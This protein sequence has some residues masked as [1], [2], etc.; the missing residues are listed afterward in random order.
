MHQKGDK[1]EI[2]NWLILRKIIFIIYSKQIIIIYLSE[3]QMKGK[4]IAKFFIRIL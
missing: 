4:L 1:E 3:S 2:K